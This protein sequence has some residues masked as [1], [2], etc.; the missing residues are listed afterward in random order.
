MS[1]WGVEQLYGYVSWSS[2][3][4]Y[5]LVVYGIMEKPGAARESQFTPECHGAAKRVTEQPG[6]SLSS[7]EYHAE[8]WDILEEHA[9][10][11]I[12]M[13]TWS[14]MEQHI[15]TIQEKARVP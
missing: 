10:S 9:K 14:I 5:N 4:T 3:D 12:K 6:V 11:I 15:C 2:L 1:D 13:F 7:L 8:D